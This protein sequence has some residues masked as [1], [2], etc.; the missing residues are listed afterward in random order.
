MRI[1]L[2]AVLALGLTATPAQAQEGMT[3]TPRA[4]ETV[5]LCAD[6]GWDVAGGTCR[7]R[8]GVAGQH[9][10]GSGVRNEPAA[11]YSVQV[12]PNFL[13][14]DTEAVAPP[15]PGAGRTR[16]TDPIGGH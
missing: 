2:I 14:P 16:W 4:G 9:Q 7:G 10:I 11:V 5:L 8:G 1:G 6:G 13:F 12:A 3:A 15:G